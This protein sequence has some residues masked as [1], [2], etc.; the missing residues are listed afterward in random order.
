MR[1]CEVCRQKIKKDDK[2][3]VLS[4]PLTATAK[5]SYQIFGKFIDNDKVIHMTC[6]C[7]FGKDLKLA[8]N[9]QQH[10]VTNNIKQAVNTKDIKINTFATVY[11]DILK[12]LQ[13]LGEKITIKDIAIFMKE[14]P[15]VKTK[16][17]FIETWFANRKSGLLKN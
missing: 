4:Y 15:T 10:Q 7:Q 11:D 16:Q 12:G 3:C 6:F 14:N 1:V 13:D 5:G 8:L 9:G 2:I 17:Q